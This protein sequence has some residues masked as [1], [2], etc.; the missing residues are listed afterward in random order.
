MKETLRLLLHGGAARG[1]RVK[2]VI[3]IDLIE[4][5]RSKRLDSLGRD[6]VS[7]QCTCSS[8]AGA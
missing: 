5:V 7:F 2:R 1:P 4:D 8:G 3:F 6:V